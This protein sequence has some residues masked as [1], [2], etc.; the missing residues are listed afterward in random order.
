M[1]VCTA[2]GAED[3]AAMLAYA[4]SQHWKPSSFTM[5]SSEGEDKE[6]GSDSSDN[7]PPAKPNTGTKTPNPDDRPRNTDHPEEAQESLEAAQSKGKSSRPSIEN[8]PN[9]P[10][11][12]GA[13]KRPKA[14]NIQ[15]GEKTKQAADRLRSRDRDDR[16]RPSYL[17]DD[18]E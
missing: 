2:D 7:K 3:T 9:Y 15:S 18:V 11:W 5:P 4:Q 16:T 10:D 6:G 1:V 8:D 13:K 14:R 12:D 17:D